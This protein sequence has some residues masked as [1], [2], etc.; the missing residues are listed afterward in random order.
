MIE[1]YVEEHFDRWLKDLMEFVKIPSISFPGFDH[2]HIET[3][4]V[5]V[6]DYMKRVGFDHVEIQRIGKSFPYVFGEVKSKKKD[7]PTILLYAHHDVQPPLRESEWVSPPFNPEIRDDRL[8]GRGSCDDKAGVMVHLAAV[9]ALL[10]CDGDIP[11]NIKVLIEGE[12]EIGSPHLESYFKQYGTLLKNNCMVLTDLANFDTGV[13]SITLSLRGL[14]ACQLEIKVLEH[15]LHSG[16][17]G[18]PLP[19]VIQIFT[20]IIS[21]MTDDSGKIFPEIKAQ[22]RDDESVDAGAFFKGIRA[23]QFMKQSGI[24]EGVSLTVPEENIAESLWLEPSFVINGVDAGEKGN[25]GNVIMDKLWARFGIRIPPGYDP[26]KI[27]S[28]VNHYFTEQAKKWGVR[29][30]LNLETLTK[31]WLTRPDHPYF[32]KAKLAFEK[33]YGCSAYYI[34]CGATIPFVLPLAESNVNVPV[35]LMGIEDP[36]SNAHAENESLSVSDF[37]KAI[38]SLLYFLMSDA[39]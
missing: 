38:L 27:F 2:A 8:Y 7:A 14:L 32:E 22:W 6:A 10:K 24:L 3:S 1:N 37:K 5:F 35:I 18:G 15:P 11:V 19:D 12:E 33:G 29:I 17:W 20:K 25:T 23:E 26:Q 28:W 16:L 39:G 13:P 31:P 30:E 36:Y 4:A 9:E 34:G 21:G